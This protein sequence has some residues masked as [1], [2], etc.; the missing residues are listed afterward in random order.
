MYNEEIKNEYLDNLISTSVKYASRSIFRYS[1]EYEEFFGKDVCDFIEPEIKEF[2]AGMGAISF[3]SLHSKCSILR[4]YTQWCIERKINKDNIN[5]Y[6]SITP[7]IIKSCINKFAENSKYLTFSELKEISKDFMNISDVALCY[8][9]F[10]G[11]YGKKGNEII[12]L[13]SDN[14][15][16]KSSEVHLVTG[17]TVKIPQEVVSILVDSC[18]EYDYIIPSD[19]RVSTLPLDITDM[20]VFKRRANARFNTEDSNNKRIVNRLIKLKTETNCRAIGI[21]TLK[22][23]GLLW[24]IKKYVDANN[25]NGDLYDNHAIQKIYKDWD[26]TF[27]PAKKVFHNKVDEYLEQ[28]K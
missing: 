17:R 2:L 8:C 1:V 3:A 25:I 7:K 27:P 16:I 26:M 12:N 10:F 18:N 24:S 21:S 23:S 11:I 14:I 4:T 9:L 15:D 22:N 13:T 5:H 28:F 6:D 20:S 19:R